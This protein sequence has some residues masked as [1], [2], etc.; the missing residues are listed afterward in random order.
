MMKIPL[1]LSQL[2]RHPP[3]PPPPHPELDAYRWLRQ[4]NS[5]S[6]SG[7]PSFSSSVKSQSNE[8]SPNGWMSARTAKF[9]LALARCCRHSR[10]GGSAGKKGWCRVKRRT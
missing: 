7:S 3:P 2:R 4:P 5:S 6:S 9:I 1:S 10:H 8:E